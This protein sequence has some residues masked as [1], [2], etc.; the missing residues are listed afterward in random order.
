[1]STIEKEKHIM[2]TQTGSTD[3]VRSLPV[4]AQ[5]LLEALNTPTAQTYGLTS[6]QIS[7]RFGVAN[8]RDLVYRLR[9]NG[10]DIISEEVVMSRGQ[11]RNKYFL[12]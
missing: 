5:R 3:T 9:K 8:P 7:R 12:G 11:I 6:R 1:M 2:Q 4:S 10:V